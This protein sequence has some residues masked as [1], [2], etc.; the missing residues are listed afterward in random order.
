MLARECAGRSIR[1]NA[2]APGVIDT[3]MMARVSEAARNELS[4]VHRATGV[5]DDRVTLLMP[6]CSCARRSRVTSRDGFSKSTVASRA[7]LVRCWKAKTG[8][9]G[10]LTL[11]GSLLVAFRSGNRLQPST[12]PNESPHALALLTRAVNESQSARPRSRN[13]SKSRL[14][15]GRRGM[16]NGRDQDSSGARLVVRARRFSARQ[17]PQRKRGDEE[18]F[19]GERR[20]AQGHKNPIPSQKLPPPI[21][22]ITTNRALSR[23]TN[24][25]RPTS[26]AGSGEVF[27]LVEAAPFRRTDI[28]RFHPSHSGKRP[29]AKPQE[30]HTERHHDKPRLEPSALVEQTWSRWAEWGPNLLVVG[31]WL[32]FFCLAFY[33]LWSVENLAPAFLTL[34]VGAVGAIILSYPILITLERPVRVTPEQALRDYYAALSHHLP[35]FRRMWLL[36]S[37]AGRISNAYGSFEGFKAYWTDRLRILREGHAGPWTPLVFEVVNFKSEKSGGKSLIDAE[38]T[39]KISVRGQRTAGPIHTIPMRINLVRGDDKMW[40]LE[41]GTLTR[42][43]S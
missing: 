18:R 27:D 6:S 2:V 24:P 14:R 1:V 8:G 13:F 19:D 26:S 43:S 23:R 15:F 40:Y 35:H 42:S 39:V 16:R 10:F 33:F 11:L 3:P 22:C 38:F 20:P 25:Q 37:T 29:A 41:N 34:V 32:L 17:A 30:R 7:D 5:W 4:K 21:G 36:L 28:R 12:T 9:A 31:A